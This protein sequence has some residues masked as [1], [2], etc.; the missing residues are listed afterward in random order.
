M[1]VIFTGVK[2]STLNILRQ[3][4]YGFMHKTEN[5]EMVFVKRVGSGGYPRFHIY[6]KAGEDGTLEVS[7]HLDQKRPSYKGATAHSGEYD[8]EE[9]KYLQN[10][11]RAITKIVEG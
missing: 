6:A 5:G 8:E 1:K 3:A 7:L 2:D 10:E 11:M 9:N 4:G